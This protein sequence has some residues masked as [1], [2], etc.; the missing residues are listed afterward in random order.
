M[1]IIVYIFNAQKPE[2]LVPVGNNSGSVTVENGGTGTYTDTREDIEKETYNISKQLD[3]IR[4]DLRLAE[5]WGETSPYYGTIDLAGVYGRG[6]TDTSKEYLVIRSRSN[7]KQDITITGWTIESFVTGEESRI[8][9]G[10]YLAYPDALNRGEAITLTPGEEAI[11]VTGDSPI[12]TS[13]HENLC[14]GYFTES[15]TF[16]PN[17]SRSCPSPLKDMERFGNIALDD[18]RCY[19]YVKTLSSCRL[20]AL[21][22]NDADIGNRCET[23]VKNAFSYEG[24][25]EYHYG[26]PYFSRGDWRIY[27]EESDTLWRRERE[28]IRLLDQNGKTVDVVEY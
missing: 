25:V 9:S 19:A 11:V 14:T 20:P 7:N 23:F 5:I 10:T 15:N 2:G 3:E 27:L 24:C 21:D 13:F 16:Y 26:D 1:V 12:G 4:N 18:D 22:P 17:I 6:G 28:I 8:P